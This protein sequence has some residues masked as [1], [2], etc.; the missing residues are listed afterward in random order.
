MLTLFLCV[1]RIAQENAA[2]KERVMRAI[3]GEI[4]EEFVSLEFATIAQEVVR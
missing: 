4:T 2:T 1:C 3:G